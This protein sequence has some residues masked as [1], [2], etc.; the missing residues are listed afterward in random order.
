MCLALCSGD[1]AVNSPPTLQIFPFMWGKQTVIKIKK[2][3]YGGLDGDKCYGEKH[4]R[5]EG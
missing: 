5:A 1:R 2:K 4:I 3:I